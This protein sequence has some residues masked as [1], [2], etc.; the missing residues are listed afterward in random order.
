MS[1]LTVKSGKG[2][3]VLK[4]SRSLVGLKSKKAKDLGK[5]TYVKE[6]K[7]KNL[8]GFQ[9]VK[10]DRRRSESLYYKLD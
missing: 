3:L 4:K 5:S 6:K 1:K 9:V 2:H 8:A 10:L 7:Y